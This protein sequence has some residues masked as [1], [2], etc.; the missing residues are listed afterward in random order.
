M[1]SILGFFRRD[2]LLQHALTVHKAGG[3]P[4]TLELFLTIWGLE[5]EFTRL[6]DNDPLVISRPKPRQL[7]GGQP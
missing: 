2:E 1:N 7:S 4:Y 5:N 3:D 6:N